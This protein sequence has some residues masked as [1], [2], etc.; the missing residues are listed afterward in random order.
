MD[1]EFSLLVV[2]DDPGLANFLQLELECEGYRVSRA[3]DGLEALS[4][5]RE[6]APD[7]LLLEVGLG[8]R[9][10]AVNIV[11]PTV[12]V[13]TSIGLDHQDWLGPDRESIGREKA[14]IFRAG[15]P[16]VVGD[17]DPP[18]SL[19]ETAARL[20]SSWYAIGDAFDE[21]TRASGDWSWRGCG[22][23][24]ARVEYT[25]LPAPRGSPAA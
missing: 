6:A 14:G 8:G 18:H 7:W 15:I 4:K 25:R 19:H 24:G 17:R 9:L 23:D 13:V 20:G 12:A 21:S 5:I 1:P 3:K 10:D 2:D 11:A 22:R 16:A